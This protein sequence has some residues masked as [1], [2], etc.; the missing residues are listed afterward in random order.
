[1]GITLFLGPFWVILG[2]F[3][4]AMPKS[5]EREFFSEKRLGAFLTLIV[6][7]LHAK[8]EENR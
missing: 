3:G 4:T 2:H 1:M 6:R 7:N 8:N 5:R